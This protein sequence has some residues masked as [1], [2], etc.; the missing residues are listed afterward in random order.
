MSDVYVACTVVCRLSCR[1]CRVLEQAPE[2]AE[3]SDAL[4]ECSTL[5]ELLEGRQ[6]ALAATLEGAFPELRC[7]VWQSEASVQAAVQVRAAHGPR[8][9]QHHTKCQCCYTS[10]DVYKLAHSV[11]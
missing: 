4:G 3:A 8:G 10:R 2:G 1:S 11:I 6:A 5:V 9:S 7:T